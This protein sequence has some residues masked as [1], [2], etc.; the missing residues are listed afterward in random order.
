MVFPQS[1]TSKQYPIDINHHNIQLQFFCFCF[2]KSEEFGDV[3]VNVDYGKKE[4]R[5]R[6]ADV[7][8]LKE[9]LKI[10]NSTDRY[11]VDSL[12]DPLQHEFQLPSCIL[13]GG[14]TE[15]LAVNVFIFMHGCSWLSRY[16]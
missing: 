13:C 10:Y 8:T 14:F 1:L 3:E 16:F 4:N 9:F 15:R 7:M 11:L 6:S 5:E 12:P 2:L